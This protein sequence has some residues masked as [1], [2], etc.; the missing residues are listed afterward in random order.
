MSFCVIL[1]HFWVNDR[2]SIFYEILDSAKLCAVHGF[3]LLAFYFSAD[4]IES[5]SLKKLQRRII[6]LLKPYLIWPLITFCVY[7]IYSLFFRG[8]ACYGFKE[9]GFQL[10]MGHTSL[11]TVMYFNWDIMVITAV[12]TGV[13]ALFQKKTAAAVLVCITAGAAVSVYSG[14]NYGM[15]SYLPYEM[16]YP[17]GRLTELLPSAAGGMVLSHV[18]FQDIKAGAGRFFRFIYAAAIFEII[19]IFYADSELEELF[20]WEHFGYGCP[21]Q[22]L[23]AF[24]LVICSYY[25]PVIT[26][27]RPFLQAAGQI[28]VYSQGIYC[29]HYTVGLALVKVAGDSWMQ[30]RSSVFSCVVI[31]V[32][33]LLLA[34][35]ISKLP[36]NW[37]RD[38]VC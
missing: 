21:V 25:I 35:G 14:F 12:F 23:A 38:I 22:V 18:C 16:R 37:C 11:E 24:F 17:L 33:S 1:C 30:M 29:I 7:N 26:V 13:F 2:N 32:I 20:Y 8:S 28:A 31:Y 15:F 10:F 9:L 3:V 27:S 4:S 34:A 6:R 36:W 19:W 5:G